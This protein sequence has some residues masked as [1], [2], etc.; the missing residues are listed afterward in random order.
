MCSMRLSPENH[1]YFLQTASDQLNA[2]LPEEIQ[3][4]GIRFVIFL[5]CIAE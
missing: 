2:H 1:E 5:F 3:V 4:L